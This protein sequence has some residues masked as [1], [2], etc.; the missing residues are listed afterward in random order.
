M[1]SCLEARKAHLAVARPLLQ[2]RFMSTR[3]TMLLAGVLLS[4]CVGGGFYPRSYGGYSPFYGSG[5]SYGGTPYYGERYWYGNRDWDDSRYDNRYY[6]RSAR[7][8]AEDQ[9]RARD[10][11]RRDQQERR[12]NLL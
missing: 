2:K 3:V 1:T 7:E 11:L 6:G 4:G 9:A 10:R 8:L 12:Q 5:S